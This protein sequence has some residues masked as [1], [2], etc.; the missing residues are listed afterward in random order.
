MFIARVREIDIQKSQ[1]PSNGFNLAAEGSTELSLVE[2]HKNFVKRSIDQLG[3]IKDVNSLVVLSG[4]LNRHFNPFFPIT[5]PIHRNER[6]PVSFAIPFTSDRTSKGQGCLFIR[7][8]F[9]RCKR[10]TCESLERRNTNKAIPTHSLN[11]YN[12]S[13]WMS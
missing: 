2:V 10:R 5:N 7:S 8:A 9:L 6:V 4:Q 13:H 1:S 11:Y 12:S 3:F